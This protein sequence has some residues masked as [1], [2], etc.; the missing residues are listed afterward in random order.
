M[1]P[2]RIHT[3]LWTA[4]LLLAGSGPLHAQLDAVEGLFEEVNAV[5]IFIQ[6]GQVTEEGKLTGDELRGAGV[7]VLIDLV[8]GGWAD[9]E[10]GLGASFL[11]GYESDDPALE[12][13]TSARA[14]P[15]VSLYASRD[16]AANRAGILSGYLGGS[17]GLLD[18]WN[19]QAY[20]ASGTAWDLE[21]QTFEMGVSVGAYWTTPVALGVFAEAGYRQREFPSVKW[22]APD[23]AA[24]PEDWRSVNLSGHYLQFG[25]QLRVKEDDA[26]EDDAI[27]PPAP[28]GVWTLVRIDGLELPI[29]LE[30]R[31]PAAA[32]VV[33]GVLRL[34]PDTAKNP[35]PG[36][37]RYSLELY[38]RPAVG[39]PADLPQSE[40]GSYTTAGSALTF[41]PDAGGR[42]QRA[43]RLAG[44]LYLTWGEH[45]LVF[46]P[47]SEEDPEDEED[48]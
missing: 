41:T 13:R 47:G 33:H 45:V 39:R 12:L 6:R 42:A 2:R 19:A 46:A 17:F 11:R 5:T 35:T 30:S 34:T 43:E 14:L 44:R 40:R 25:V 24:V 22:T 23:G 4:A 10:L 36:A 7:E 16:L 32:H 20:D 21:A 3:A 1:Q 15:T 37:G 9:L 26:N 38:V 31:D 29:A 18:L 27:T 48:S 8:S 28:A